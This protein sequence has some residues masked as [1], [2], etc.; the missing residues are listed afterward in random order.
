[1]RKVARV[2][3]LRELGHHHVVAFV[4]VAR[5]AKVCIVTVFRTFSP[6]TG[7]APLAALA[8]VVV[9]GT[10]GLIFI[11]VPPRPR[12]CCFAATALWA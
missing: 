6:T 8:A 1:M 10:C 3:G 11:G 2:A 5:A 12:L 4:A 7:E 9:P